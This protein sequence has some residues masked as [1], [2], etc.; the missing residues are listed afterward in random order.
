MNEGERRR[1]W[2]GKSFKTDDQG[3]RRAAGHVSRC[4]TFGGVTPRCPWYFPP[5]SL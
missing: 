4:Y 5:R 3:P 1:N 2:L